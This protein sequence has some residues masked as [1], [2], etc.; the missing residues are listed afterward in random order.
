MAGLRPDTAE[1][2]ARRVRE[3]T[4]LTLLAAFEQEFQVLASLDGRAVLLARRAP[5]RDPFGPEVM[6]ALGGRA[7][8]PGPLSPNMGA[9]S[10]R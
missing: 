7:S 4:G 2:R 3:T 10:S 9:T 6:A 1:G 8:S 5:A